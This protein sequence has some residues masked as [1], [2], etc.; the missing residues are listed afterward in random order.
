M[1]WS[2]RRPAGSC[3]DFSVAVGSMLVAGFL[4]AGAESMNANENAEAGK[5]YIARVN[6]RYDYRF[7]KGKPFLPSNATTEDGQFI[8]PGTFPSAAY[9][10][11]SHEEAWHEWRESLHANSFRAPFYKK[12]VDLLT[13]A[14]GVEFT[15]HCEGCHNPIALLSGA[16]TKDTIVTNREFDNDGITC[17]VCHSIQRLLPQS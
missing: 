14:K 17:L 12:N 1:L 10:R 15:R 6:K 4:L 2:A 16:I 9:C 8:Q 3:Q 7:G 13:N 11:H 5:E